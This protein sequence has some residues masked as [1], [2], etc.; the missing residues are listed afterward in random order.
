MGFRL[1]GNNGNMT[2]RY[3][4]T[5]ATEKEIY[6]SISLMMHFCAIFIKDNRATDKILYVLVDNL[7]IISH[8]FA[9]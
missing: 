9:L 6:L 2:C 8:N 5:D 4:R 1:S 3:I 7:G